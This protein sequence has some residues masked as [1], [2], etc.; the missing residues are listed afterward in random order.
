MTTT[1][2][3][4]LTRQLTHYTVAPGDITTMANRLSEA[5]R[6]FRACNFAPFD[7]PVCSILVYLGEATRAP[8]PGTGATPGSILAHVEQDTFVL[9]FRPTDASSDFP[10]TDFPRR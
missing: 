3:R 8:K 6:A 5:Q 4:T 1:L 9:W 10:A 7:V 2:E